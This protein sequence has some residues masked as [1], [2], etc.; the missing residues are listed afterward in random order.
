MEFPFEPIARDPACDFCSGRRE[1][2]KLGI[3][4]AYCISL[5]EQPERAAYAARHFHEIGLCH[6]VTFQRPRRAKTNR[7]L[8]IWQSHRAVAREALA[9][10]QRR[11]LILEDDVAFRQPIPE[12]LPRIE[13][14][15][16]DL[17]RDWHAL[18]LGHIPMQAYFVAPGLM[19]ARSGGIHAYIAN[20]P[21]LEWYDKTPPRSAEVPMWPLIAPSVDSA[22]SVLPGMYAVYPMMALQK[23]FGESRV[24]RHRTLDGK[25]R[26][27]F[28][29]ERWRNFYLF[30]LPPW[31]EASAALLSPFHRWTMDWFIRRIEAKSRDARAIRDS[32]LFDDNFYLEINPDVAAAG[33]APLTHY[34]EFGA[35]EGR[36][37]NASFDP[38]FYAAHAQGLKAGENP[39]LHYITKGRALGLP[40]RPG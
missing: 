34:M 8:A 19:R 4:A 28:D 27:L 14:A 38:A 5:V 35:A 16:A 18:Y 2:P 33:V 15:L 40:T 39:L 20:T 11:V 30:D 7:G 25:R 13:R 26:S 22:T 31:A 10:G 24:D 17:P 3:D 12:L 37:P 6:Y 9:K 23:D 32:G 1:A 29:F 36:A 21:L